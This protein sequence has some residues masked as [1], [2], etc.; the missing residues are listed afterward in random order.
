MRACGWRTDVPHPLPLSD[1]E[2]LLRYRPHASTAA[3]EEATT[4][5]AHTASARQE[6]SDE[7]L[8]VAAVRDPA[9]FAAIY[10][11]YRLPVY[12]FALAGGADEDTAM[13][14]VGDTFERAFV[15]LPRYRP[16]GGGLPAWLFRIA[17]N[18]LTDE[19]RHRR[20]LTDLRAVS[21]RATPDPP[22]DPDLHQAIAKLPPD[23]RE[24][25][26]LRYAAGLTAAEIGAVIGKRPAAVQKLIERALIN[27]R[28]ALHER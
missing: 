1:S 4:L 26:A 25:I 23:A 15:H 14:I 12:R 19:R 16:I 2:R 8:V 28:E 3:L 27:L 11:R 13:E 20:R 7:V 10:E 21:E 24:A 6:V 18:T 9:A 22:R 5:E 17:R